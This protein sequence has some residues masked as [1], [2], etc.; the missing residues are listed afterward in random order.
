MATKAQRQR[1]KRKGGKRKED[2]LD[3]RRKAQQAE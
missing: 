2:P 1:E 3:G